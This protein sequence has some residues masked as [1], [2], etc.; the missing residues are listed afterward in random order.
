MYNVYDEY[1]VIL[2]KIYN[3]ALVKFFQICEI[4]EATEDLVFLI[5]S[6]TPSI[7]FIGFVG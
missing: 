2:Y 4:L 7:V 3:S 1:L 5:Q 6:E